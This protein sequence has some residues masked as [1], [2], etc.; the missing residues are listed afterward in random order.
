VARFWIP[1]HWAYVA[2]LPKTS[3]GKID[4]KELR[5]LYAEGRI[6]LR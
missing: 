4:K 6:Q 2:E 1:E 5:R 3:V